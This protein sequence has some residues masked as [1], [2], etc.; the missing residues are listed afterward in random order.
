M[1][2]QTTKLTLAALTTAAL[3]GSANAAP[4]LDDFSSDTSANYTGTDT[5]GSGGSFS[6]SGG[7]LSVLSSGTHAVFHNSAQLEVG[8]T[9][10][11]DIVRT[12]GDIRLSVSTAPVGP[13]FGG[14][15]GLRLKYVGS[16]TLQV[17]AYGGGSTNVID[18]TIDSSSVTLFITRDDAD[19]FTVGHNSGSG[20]VS[21]GAFDVTGLTS[22]G[23][24]IGVENFGNTNSSDPN[25]FDNLQIVPEPGSLAL[26]G[27]GGLLIARR[28]RG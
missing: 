13:N 2:G 20:D 3:V 21:L 28:R 19:T 7:T 23:L 6:I 22:D 16:T 15:N 24:F 27:L 14:N 25:T 12:G 18:A 11:V 10:S 26:L 1:L 17:Q 4:F 9:A 8:E 5:F